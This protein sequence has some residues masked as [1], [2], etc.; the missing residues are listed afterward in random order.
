M[1]DGLPELLYSD[2]L[3]C[4]ALTFSLMRHLYLLVD[5]NCYKGFNQRLDAS[6]TVMRGFRQLYNSEFSEFQN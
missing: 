6:S 1:I 4:L 3:F 2:L 5:H